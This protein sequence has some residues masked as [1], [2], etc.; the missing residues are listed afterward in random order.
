[1]S[2]EGVYSNRYLMNFVHPQVGKLVVLD[3]RLGDDA[4]Q[5]Q[6][7]AVQKAIEESSR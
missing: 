6:L 2:D 1:M 3:G 5:Y 4:L 7:K